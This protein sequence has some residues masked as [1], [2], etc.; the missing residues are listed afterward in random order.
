[1]ANSTEMQMK[2]TGM[3]MSRKML[4]QTAEDTTGNGEQYAVR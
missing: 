2:W 1:M 3:A 4:K